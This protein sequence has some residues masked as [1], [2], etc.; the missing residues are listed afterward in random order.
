MEVEGVEAGAQVAGFLVASDDRRAV[1]AEV[2][3]KGA[4]LWVVQVCCVD[5][6]V[7]LLLG[8]GAWWKSQA[9]GHGTR[10]GSSQRLRLP[11]QVLLLPKL[12][13]RPDLRNFPSDTALLRRIRPK[14]R[15]P[16]PDR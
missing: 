10:V 12:L 11:R 16:V 6:A 7:A 13:L 5:T 4:M 1:V 8:C 15:P 14:S 9:G 3:G 2:A